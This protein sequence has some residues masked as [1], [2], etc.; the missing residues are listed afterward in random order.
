MN[1][2]ATKHFIYS[3]S[4]KGGIYPNKLPLTGY[5]NGIEVARQEPPPVLNDRCL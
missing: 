3:L 4:S 1:K 5:F 2:Y